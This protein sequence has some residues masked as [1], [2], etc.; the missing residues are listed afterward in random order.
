MASTALSYFMMMESNTMALCIGLSAGL[1]Y[2]KWIG[3]QSN[4]IPGYLIFEY[5]N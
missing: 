3:T 2:F 1:E 5:L 4:N